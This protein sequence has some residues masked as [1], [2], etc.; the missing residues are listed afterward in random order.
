MFCLSVCP[1]VTKTN[2]LSMYMEISVYCENHTKN[3]NKLCEKETSGYKTVG[4]CNDH[5]ALKCLTP[6]N[7]STESPENILLIL[8]RGHP[9]VSEVH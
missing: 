1:S 5:C 6:V 2:L 7:L 8:G 3:S 4:R 9:V